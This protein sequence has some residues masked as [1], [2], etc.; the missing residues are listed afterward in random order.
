MG[1]LPVGITSIEKPLQDRL[2][3]WKEIAAYLK[4]DVTTVQRW[5]KREGMPIHRHL[6]DRMG[7]VYASR[8]ELDAWTR[9][10][11]PRPSEGGNDRPP[12][13]SSTTAEVEATSSEKQN[14]AAHR[15]WAWLAALA[16]LAVLASGAV[17][18]LK[19][20]EQFWHNPI[21]EGRFQT[22]TDFGGISEAAAISRDGNLVAF[23]SDRDGPMDVWV[24][25]VGSGEYHNLTHGSFP[26]LV[27][28][29]IRTLAFT[30]DAS[31]VTFWLRRPE[32]SGGE[33]IGTWAVPTLGGLPR[34]YLDG[35]AEFDWSRDGT[36]L[37][38][39]TSAAGDPLYVAKDGQLS[40]AKLIFS[41]AASGLHSHFPL[42]SPDGAFL[43]FVHGSIPDKLD[44]WRIRSG[45]GTPERITF[46]DAAM[47]SP[48][49]L[50]GRTLLYL[51]TDA[52]G[53]GPWL[54]GLDVERRIP[55]RLTLGP[56]RY[57][58]LAVSADG[59]HL[60][61]TLASPKRTLWRLSTATSLAAV[62]TQ[63]PLS[64]GTGFLPRLGPDYLLYVS[65]AGSGEG[66]WK[67]VNG[68]AT[69][70]WHAPGAHILGAPA[71]SSDGHLIA[72]S[73]RM[74][75]RSLLDVMQ[76]DGTGAHTVCDSLD[77]DGAPAWSPDGRFVTTAAKDHG[78]PHLV[79]VAVD[80]RP[81]AIL[82]P[83]YSLDPVWS[84]DGR[85]V[86]YTGLDIGTTFAV[87]MLPAQPS[88]PPMPTLTLTRGAR[89]LVVLQAGRSVVFLEGSIQHK[90]LAQ[91]DLQTGMEHP[92]I[93]LPS[94][95]DVSNFDLSPDGREIILERVQEHS[96]VML[97]DLP[98]R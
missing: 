23:L 17:F 98:T 50:N 74:D 60:A 14:C 44:L 20:T 25:Q 76:A 48:V 63:V 93:T 68:K 94:G 90:D 61:V 81:P 6:H 58:S 55:H 21:A 80:G 39:H 53:S 64:T 73:V 78:T 88:A 72:F 67:S 69:Q 5:E 18:W 12:P 3:S 1:E 65:T 40:G 9:S 26:G 87:K 30:P 91:M 8:A 24:T 43:Y 47:M 75:G 82:V 10:R 13:P 22:V 42:W 16:G 62:P 36:Q 56:E 11:N 86:L 2:D 46:H 33:N 27:N 84:P 71:I 51:A 92:W 35:V 83:D 89:H 41:T 97:L 15:G 77:L 7:S 54:Y 52:D 49:L 34:P 70:L 95:F 29:S 4:R 66:I 96:E 19:N 79:Q 57:T 45:G 85:F 28:P 31:L 32:G 37:A 38:F 59:H